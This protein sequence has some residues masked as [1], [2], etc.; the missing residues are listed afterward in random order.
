M[1][2]FIGVRWA[3]STPRMRETR[4]SADDGRECRGGASRAT[5]GAFLLIATNLSVYMSKSR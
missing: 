1:R 2:L 3:V 5:A 4:V